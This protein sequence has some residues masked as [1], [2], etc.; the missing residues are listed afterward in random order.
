MGQSDCGGPIKFRTVVHVR[1]LPPAPNPMGTGQPD[2]GNSQSGE[3]GAV[4]DRLH[5]QDIHPAVP[6]RLYL[7]L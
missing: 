3:G 5:S 1:T 6:E 7:G 4:P 2:M